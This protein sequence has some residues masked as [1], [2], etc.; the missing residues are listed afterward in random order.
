VAVVSV[1]LMW[2]PM[3]MSSKPV[4]E[5]SR[6]T[7]SPRSRGTET[8]LMADRSLKQTKAV[9]TWA[10]AASTVPHGC[11]VRSSRQVTSRSALAGA[12]F[13]TRY[14]SSPGGAMAAA[15]T[16][17]GHVAVTGGH[18]WYRVVGDGDAIPLVTVHGGPGATHDY[19][20]PLSALA[21]ERP[22]VFYDQ[23]GAGKSDAPDD[24]NLWT[25]DRLV[26]ELGRLLDELD[27]ARVH[28]LGQSWGAIVAAE[29]ALQR[30]DRLVGVVLADPCLS[31]PRFAA[32]A[33]ALR[34]AL[35]AGPG[36]DSTGHTNWATSCSPANRSGG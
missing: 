19:L 35:P 16:Q 31:M 1:G 36:P 10:K 4:M 33:A 9:G 7:S 25:N 26:D 15:A 30:P 8:T 34:A 11:S 22:V 5:M 20:E 27:L 28:L 3:T 32:G 18:V 13:R 21:D 17:E 23:L 24:V 6:G 14:R 12:L 2:R 29:Y